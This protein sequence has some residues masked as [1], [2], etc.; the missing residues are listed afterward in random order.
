[1]IILGI[2]TSCDETAVAIVRDDG[3]IL[4]N[5]VLSQLDEHRAFGGVV[6][7]IAARAHMDHLDTLIRAAM[8]DAKIDFKDLD[9]VAAT[10]GPGLIGGVMVGMMAG[11]AIA[12]AHELPFIAINHLEAHALTPR[13]T[14]DVAFPYLLLLVSGGH[15]Q[16]L[17]AE[18]VGVYRRW[19]TT[20]DDAAGE[21][22]DKSAKV[23]GLPYPGGPNMERAA[24]T[25]TDTAAALA[26]FPLPR[27]MKGRKDCD[28][29]F[30]GLKTAV[31]VHVDA[32]P[33][34]ELNPADVAMLARSFEAAMCDT[35]T[36]RC[37]QAIRRFKETYRTDRPTLVVSGGVAANTALR[38]ALEDISAASGLRFVAPPQKLCSDNGAMIAWA[39]IEHLRL[40]H[41]SDLHFAA[42]PR[43]PLDPD[44]EPK[45]GAG[46]KA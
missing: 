4:S 40:G 24:R 32:L 25:C 42:R 35:I 21:C 13:L 46:V 44:A 6:P 11:K 41:H 10:C 5:L 43:W 7:E 12:A 33:Q 15:T 45:R 39:G 20:I 16:I 3:T 19:G 17:V 8:D 29:S 30:S 26:R 1:M 38:A 37:A 28:F 22:F 27:P 31:R 34:G 14:D 23:M 36:D 18:N 2:E 9:G